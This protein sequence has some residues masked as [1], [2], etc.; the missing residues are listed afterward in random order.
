MLN[1]ILFCSLVLFVVAICFWF[2]V[3]NHGLWR[4]I[5][6]KTHLWLGI[7]SGIVLFIVC[8]TGTLLVFDEEITMFLERDK[9]FV[10]YP[11]KSPLNMDD[12]ISKVEQNLNGKVETITRFNSRN[13]TSYLMLLKI[14]NAESKTHDEYLI[15]PYTGKTLG[16]YSSPL[17]K[18]FH[19]VTVTHCTLF[20]PYPVG[21]IVVG[22]ATLIFVIVALSGLCLW[23]P[24]NFRNIKSWKTGFIIRF[25]NGKNQLIGDLH[26]TLGFYV[27]IPMLLMALTG[28]TWSFEWFHHGVKMIF[29]IQHPHE[30]P[31]KSL[32]QNPNIKQLPLDFF[33]KK[34]EEIFPSNQDRKRFFFIPKHENDSM[35]VMDWRVG[36]VELT[37]EDVVHFD[38]YTGE[39]LR[40]KRFEDIPAGARFVSLFYDLHV[41]SIFGLSTK[42]LY[43]FA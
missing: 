30:S 37:G 9:Y 25:R 7:I 36:M 14:E 24:A 31:I 38:Q 27:L 32:H 15:D 35:V 19:I 23:L 34:A 6:Y 28:L 33:V 17:L 26:K 16:K 1:F 2:R 20:L 39:V 29:H 10:S 4:R 11:D 5:L 3:W 21:R 43:F 18:F 40:L 13:D 12:L 22:S 42:I 41:G 8:L